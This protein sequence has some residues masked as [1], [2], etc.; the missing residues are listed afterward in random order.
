MNDRRLLILFLASGGLMALALLLFVS[1]E[2]DMNAMKEARQGEEHTVRSLHLHMDEN[3]L[4]KL[5]ESDPHGNESYPVRV[6]FDDEEKTFQA[7]VRF[8]GH[9]SRDF[10][11]KSLRLAFDE[12]GLFFTD[13]QVINLNAS[14]TDPSLMVEKL[15]M[16][17]FRE[18]GLYAPEISYA[19]VYINDVYEG[20]FLLTDRV[21]E[22]FLKRN[23]LNPNGTLVRDRGRHLDSEE[24]LDGAS[25]FGVDL[26]EVDDVE[27]YLKNAFDYRGNP[28]WSALEDL[29][30]FVHDAP[31]NDDYY[32]GLKE[33]VDMDSF[34]AF[35]M[36]HDIVQ[37]IDAY[38]DDYWLYLDHE[39]PEAKWIFIPW[40]KDLTF[41]RIWWPDLN[42]THNNFTVQINPPFVWTFDNMLVMKATTSEKFLAHYQNKM[43]DFLADTF[44]L[45]VMGPLV[46][47][48]RKLVDLHIESAQGQAAF[49]KHTANSYLP[50]EERELFSDR[51]LAFVDLRNH[52]LS[53]YLSSKEE[54]QA[55][56]SEQSLVGQ[57]EDALVW[58]DDLGVVL[59]TF[60][61]D[62]AVEGIFTSLK[63]EETLDENNLRVKTF[64]LN[65]VG[66]PVEGMLTLYYGDYHDFL[67]REQLFVWDQELKSEAVWH[68]HPFLY[69][70]SIPLKLESDM[71]FVFREKEKEKEIE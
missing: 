17:L 2:G 39:D 23:G 3:D 30:R 55:F 60:K 48:L 70:V 35:M 21:D 59:G 63:L 4:K 64:S 69:T 62:G 68:H 58:V 51:I 27:G 12:A 7:Q 43:A 19:N 41:G 61:P 34:V 57:G 13:A 53:A 22:H 32:D 33:Y 56:F 18:A 29:I 65:Y 38:G 14:F 9:S 36:M 11:K 46:H 25:T 26:S 52:Y 5:Y 31:Y 42:L 40:D 15:S 1:M 16:D 24:Q 8:R 45:Q 37:D 44:N 28:N 50:E 20:T 47:D 71:T 66:G 67:K 6:R 49:E 54:P 10:S